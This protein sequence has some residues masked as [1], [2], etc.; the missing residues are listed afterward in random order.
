MSTQALPQAAPTKVLSAIHN[1]PRRTTTAY[2]RE[3]PRAPG[4]ENIPPGTKGH[5]A[6]LTA[7]AILVSDLSIY[8]QP[9]DPRLRWL[10]KDGQVIVKVRVPATDDLWKFRVPEDVTLAAFLP[11]VE[12]KVGG[13]VILSILPAEGFTNIES[14]TAFRSWLRARVQK[15]KNRPLTAHMVL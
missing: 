2:I 7:P 11:R 10:P 6:R 5:R 12:A 3:A 15:G 4:K 9:E 14:E 8:T 13:P 1:L